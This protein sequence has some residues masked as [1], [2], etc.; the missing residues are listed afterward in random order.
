VGW[1]LHLIP[2]WLGIALDHWHFFKSACDN[3]RANL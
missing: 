2:S 3:A 1:L